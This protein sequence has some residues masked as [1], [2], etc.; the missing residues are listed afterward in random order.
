MYY[1][2]SLHCYT[3]TSVAIHLQLDKKSTQSGGR[4][5]IVA[6]ALATYYCGPGSIPARSHVWVGLVLLREFLSAG[7]SGYPPSTK[8]YVH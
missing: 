1:L 3:H 8:K 6:R 5:G 2:H 4:Y 7:F